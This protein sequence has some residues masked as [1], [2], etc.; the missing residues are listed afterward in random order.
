[1]ASKGDA[2]FDGDGGGVISGERAAVK[3]RGGG[4]GG[5]RFEEIGTPASQSHGRFLADRWIETLGLVKGWRRTKK[6]Q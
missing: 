3:E 4:C 5:E 1:M 6:E 2:G